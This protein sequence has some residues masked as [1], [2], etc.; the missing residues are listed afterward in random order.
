M[1]EP[2]GWSSS[3]SAEAAA[4]A[5]YTSPPRSCSRT[6]GARPEISV[7]RSACAAEASSTRGAGVVEDV[8]LLVGGE[9]EVD[10]DQVEAAAQR[11]PVGD[12]VERAV[13]AQQRDR[14]ARPQPGVAQ[15]VGQP[16]RLL[17]EL[18]V[19]Q[20]LAGPRHDDGRL[21]GELARERARV[22]AVTPSPRRRLGVEVSV[23]ASAPCRAWGPCPASASWPWLAGL[24]R[25]SRAC[26]GAAFPLCSSVGLLV[27]GAPSPWCCA[28]AR[29]AGAAVVTACAATAAGWASAGAAVSATAAV[30]AAGR[31][32]G[33]A[34]A[35]RGSGVRPERPGGRERGHQ[36]RGRGAGQPATAVRRGRGGRGGR[37][38]RSGS[39]GQHAGRGV[40]RA[41]PGGDLGGG[42]PGGRVARGHRGQERGASRRAGRP[43]RPGARREPGEGALGRACRRTPGRR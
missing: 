15:H 14:V 30:L 2:A 32:D 20:G 4:I 5:S 6:P 7:A 29:G 26:R 36:E 1:S 24:A 18:G 42:G 19:G 41:Q 8:G 35:D 40:R 9:V 33:A 37:S 22:H 16:D 27:L 25:A 13:L 38:G 43:A 23:R 34:P 11:R 39:R 10:R 28:V 3:G 31:W 17:L 12:Q 21:V